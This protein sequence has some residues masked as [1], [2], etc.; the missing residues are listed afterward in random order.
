MTSRHAAWAP[1]TSLRAL[2]ITLVLCLLCAIVGPRAAHAGPRIIEQISVG[3]TGSNGAFDAEFKAASPDASRVIFTTSES[4]VGAD[5]DNGLDVYERW[6]GETTLLSTGPADDNQGLVDSVVFASEDASRVFFTATGSLV[7]GDTDDATDLYERSGGV[8]TLIST[9]PAAGDVPQHVAFG[10]PSN[11]TISADGSH[12][13]FQTYEALVPADT[14]DALDL[15]ERVGGETRLITGLADQY[16]SDWSGLSPD[17]SRVFFS[18]RTALVGADTDASWDIY[19]R[20]DGENHLVSTGPAGGN[21]NVDVFLVESSVDGTRAFFATEESL[22]AAD[23][24]NSSDLYERSGG[25]TTLLTGGSADHVELQE[26]SDDGSR[27][28]FTTTESLAATDTD[29]RVDVYEHHLGQI[30]HVSIG[31]S[32]GNGPAAATPEGISRDGSRVFFRTNESLLGADTDAV[33]DVYERSGGVTTLVSAGGNGAFAT[34]FQGLSSDGS[35]V[36]FSTVEALVAADTDTLGDVYERVAGQHTL[37]WDGPAIAPGLVAPT[38]IDTSWDGA[39]VFDGRR[40]LASTVDPVLAQ[41]TDSGQTDIYAAVLAAPVGDGDGDGIHD[42]VDLDPENASSAFGDGSGTTGSI[43]PTG[44]L[45]VAVE[46]AAAPDGVRIRVTSG[47]G[48]VTFSVC[49]GFSLKVSAGSEVVVTCGSV[50]V[51]VVLGSTEIVL[52]DGVIVAVT[53]GAAARVAQRPD[54]SY[55]VE[56]LGGPGD[57]PITVIKDGVVTPVGPGETVGTNAAPVAQPNAYTVVGGATLAVPAPGVLANDSDD[58][59]DPLTAQVGTTTTRGTLALNAKGSFTYTPGENT[60]GTDSFTYTA[61]DGTTSSNIATVTITVQAGCDGRRATRVGTA[62]NDTLGGSGGNDVIVGLGGNDTIGPGS[63]V[64]IVCGGSGNDSVSAGSGNDAV[65]G[66]S[67]NDILDGGSGNDRLL[68]E[69]GL[70]RLLGGGDNDTLDGGPGTP[71]HCNGEGGSDT[72]TA[73][74]TILKVP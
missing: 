47:I 27:V 45:S 66:G 57:P 73:C 54:G 48:Q 32:G 8:T 53:A 50:S 46:D 49:G 74:E 58:D 72:A 16:F 9:G 29:T 34:T 64:D 3:P 21:G 2:L 7:A 39:R 70:D 26:I 19:E 22:V 52:D 41:D 15:Y 10:V 42:A 24:D 31:P 51:D 11:R 43:G 38:L 65:F 68:G 30:T 12:V 60:V 4:L 17:G 5:I 67:G 69:S 36:F 18:T 33:R 14:D 59:S 63:G 56:N 61:N 13:L 25:Q 35:R 23:T 6:N 40:L 62:G 55:S 28:F 71:D 20:S 1:A 37:V 44:L